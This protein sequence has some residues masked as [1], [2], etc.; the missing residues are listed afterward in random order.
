VKQ[1]SNRKETSRIGKNIRK[2]RMEAGF[3]IDDIS[4]MTG[5]GKSRISI[6][7][8]GG[9][10][11]TSHLIEIAKAIGVHPKEIF[12]IPFLIKPRYRLSPKRQGRSRL[13]FRI[14]KL[15]EETDFFNSPIF[16]KEVA[17]FLRD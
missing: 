17:K 6:I 14:N 12:N 3:S 15:Y 5:Y 7:E 13:T 16:V 11:T 1:N 4:D 10:T 9:E 8:N 2:L